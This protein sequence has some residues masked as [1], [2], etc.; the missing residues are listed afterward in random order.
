MTLR[1]DLSPDSEARLRDRASASGVSPEE[2]A[3][4][5]VEQAVND[6]N[7]ARSNGVGAGGVGGLPIAES[8]RRSG[9][10][11]EWFR[12]HPAKPGVPPVDDGRGSIYAGRGE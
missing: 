2:Y 12:S 8:Q 4:R 3:R 9:A 10:L 7:G 1:F 6:S 5:V 11:D